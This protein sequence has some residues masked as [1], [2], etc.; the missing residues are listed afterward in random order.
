MCLLMVKLPPSSCSS[1]LDSKPL[2][3][4]GCCSFTANCY[5]RQH[6]A[7]TQPNCRYV[8]AAVCMFVLILKNTKYDLKMAVKKQVAVLTFSSNV[9]GQLTSA[10]FAAS[11]LVGYGCF[12]G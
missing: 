6:E 2:F 10:N 7:E 3:L 9:L 1:T 11:L 5:L 12:E 8:S 4:F